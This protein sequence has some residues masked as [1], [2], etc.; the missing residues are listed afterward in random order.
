MELKRTLR[1]QRLTYA[2]IAKALKLSLPTI[3]RMFSRG[4]FTL[5]R[6]ER[7]CDLASCSLA[8]IAARAH[9]RSVPRQRYIYEKTLQDFLSSSFSGP[10]EEFW[11]HGSQ[12]S[13][14]S[15][16]ALKRALQAAARE[17]AVIV[18]GERAATRDRR[19]AAFVLALRR[20]SYSGFAPFERQLPPAGA[21]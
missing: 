19:G 4:D 9:E 11:F 6:F 7:I 17:C 3:K 2:Q 12:V 15:L 13:D 14:A 21:D 18:D 8:D 5:R 20:W 1:G 16:A 10:D